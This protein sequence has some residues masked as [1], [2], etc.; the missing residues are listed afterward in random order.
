MH[1]SIMSYSLASIT[2][3]IHQQCTFNSNVNHN[4][5]PAVRQFLLLLWALKW[6][7]RPA[8]FH[9]SHSQTFPKSTGFSCWL[10]NLSAKPTVVSSNCEYNIIAMVGQQ[11][12]QTMAKSQSSMGFCSGVPVRK[13]AANICTLIAMQPKGSTKSFHEI[14]VLCLSN[15]I[16]IPGW[17]PKMLNIFIGQFGATNPSFGI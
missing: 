13:L 2:K 12:E 15:E 5:H 3:Q 4:G 9:D 11:I 16:Q 8:R 17:Q 1:V 7:G 10:A 14:W 6:G